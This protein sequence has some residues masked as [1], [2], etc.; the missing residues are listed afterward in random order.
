MSSTNLD[1]FRNRVESVSYCIAFRY[2]HAY[3]FVMEETKLKEA[4]AARLR[5][6]RARLNLTLAQAAEKAGIHLMSIS[7]WENGSLP[8]VG[9]LYRLA[10]AYGVEA[11]DLLPPMASVDDLPKGRKR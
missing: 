7:R 5:A 9:A 2:C 10:D 4:V 8:T 3:I 1:Y 11:V 6:E